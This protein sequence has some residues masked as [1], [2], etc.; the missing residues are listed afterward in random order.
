MIGAFPF[1]DQSDHSE[2]G[3]PLGG[4]GSPQGS[5]CTSD[6]LKRGTG[7]YLLSRALHVVRVWSNCGNG[8]EAAQL[9]CVWETMQ[10]A[11]SCVHAGKVI[12]YCASPL[13]IVSGYSLSLSC[14][15]RIVGPRGRWYPGV[16]SGSVVVRPCAHGIVR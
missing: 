15:T 12:V 7:R 10:H 16:S 2:G 4:R 1:T 11:L 14:V 3:S 13:C 6:A 8:L 5:R 9:T